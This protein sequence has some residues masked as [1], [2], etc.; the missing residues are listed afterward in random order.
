MQSTSGEED[1]VEEGRL[2]QEAVNRNEARALR[3]VERAQRKWDDGI[4]NKKGVIR[5]VEVP[6]GSLREGMEDTE[7]ESV[8]HRFSCRAGR[9]ECVEVIAQIAMKSEDAE[10][11][12]EEA[13]MTRQRGSRSLQG[14]GEAQRGGAEEPVPGKSAFTLIGSYPLFRASLVR[15]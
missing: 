10:R 13:T 4:V 2:D 9:G 11:W 12:S 3:A 15:L 1:V 6:Q 5:T 8:Q 14:G 7:E